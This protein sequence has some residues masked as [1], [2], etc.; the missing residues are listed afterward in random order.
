LSGTF[1]ML[2]INNFFLMLIFYSIFGG[3]CLNFLFVKVF[4]CSQKINFM[5]GL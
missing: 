2:S 1:M 5:R 4:Y 3:K